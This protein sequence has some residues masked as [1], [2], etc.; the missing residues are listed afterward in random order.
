MP[1]G[2]VE[3]RITIK[4]A[5]DAPADS[6]GSRVLVDRIWPRGVSRDALR[7]D[8]WAKGVAPSTELRKWFDHDPA[9]W[10][11]FKD[12]YFRELDEQPR[13]VGALLTKA[14]AGSLTLVFGAK[15]MDCNN[16]AALKEFLERQAA[17]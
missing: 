11:A 17:K 6:D 15:N 2:I 12:R 10:A 14:R 16:A 3:L 5:Y 9:K 1:D 4:R 7:L 8:D 13:A